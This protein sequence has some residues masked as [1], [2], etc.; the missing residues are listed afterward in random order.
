MNGELRLGGVTAGDLRASFRGEVYGDAAGMTEAW[1][2]DHV[3]R[4]DVDLARSLRWYAG[5]R[6]AGAA[7][8]AFRGTRA[9]VGAFGVVPEFRGH[10]LGAQ[11]VQDTLAVARDAGAASVELEVL[12]HNNAAI[13][14]YERGGFRRAGDLVV[15]TRAPV[16]VLPWNP[17]AASK[18]LVGDLAA[19]TAI[20]RRPPTCWQREPTSVAAAAPFETVLL[21]AAEMPEAYAFVRRT[22]PDARVLDAG[23]GHAASAR[24]LLGAL[25]AVF[26]RETLMLMNEPPHGALHET[27]AT[28]GGWREL[29]RQHRMRTDLNPGQR[30]AS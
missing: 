22:R 18:I 5:D 17:R 4:N 8:L 27:L 25:D 13:R 10:G 15:W 26:A 3:R 20:A 2:D 12:A 19:V 1:F 30:R 14:L 21:G 7:L 23:A 9:W 29:T 16:A 28:R 6:L 11:F 24:A